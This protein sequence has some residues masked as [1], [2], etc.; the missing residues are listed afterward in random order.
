MVFSMMML[1]EDAI[2][3]IMPLIITAMQS[4]MSRRLRFN[5]VLLAIVKT[6]A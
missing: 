1:D 2:S 4:G 6:T 3:V 5:P